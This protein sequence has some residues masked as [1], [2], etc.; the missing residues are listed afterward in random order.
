MNP[1][2]A[3]WQKREQNEAWGERYR[4]ALKNGFSDGDASQ[5]ADLVRHNQQENER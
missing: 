2:V 3:A 4:L 5:A 1:H